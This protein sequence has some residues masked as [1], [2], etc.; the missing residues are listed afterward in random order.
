MMN[1]NELNCQGVV[2]L[3][4]DYLENA[5]LPTM[6]EQFEEHVAECPGCQNYVEQIQLT[7]SMLRQISQ[8][9]T[10]AITKQE[11]LQVFQNWKQ[12]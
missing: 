10:S 3:V 2:E 5:L 1:E 9:P 12:E 6:K 4:T 7:I 11:L 8:E